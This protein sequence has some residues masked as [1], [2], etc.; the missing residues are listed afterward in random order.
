MSAPPI[1]LKGATFV[2]TGKLATMQ[3]KEA[4]DILRLLAAPLAQ[5]PSAFAH[6]L[7]AADLLSSGGREVVIAGDRPDLVAAVHRR[8]LPDAERFRTGC[9]ARRPGR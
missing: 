4:E 1:D 2:F 6:L 8:W 3:R 9:S 5:H 7:Q